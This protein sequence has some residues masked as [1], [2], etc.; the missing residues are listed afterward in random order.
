L[1]KDGVPPAA[2]RPW[3]HLSVIGNLQAIEVRSRGVARAVFIT[4]VWFQP[5]C[6]HYHLG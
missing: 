4:P 5:E 2:K 6:R 1:T 3:P